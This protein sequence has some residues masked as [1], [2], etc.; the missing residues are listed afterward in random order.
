MEDP[1]YGDQF[2]RD[3]LT[4]GQ[5]IEMK[6]FE[7]RDEIITRLADTESLLGKLSD[8]A[9]G[10]TDTILDILDNAFGPERKKV[11][12]DPE[13]AE[14]NAGQVVLIT[15]EDIAE[16]K[17]MPTRKIDMAAFMTPRDADQYT[18]GGYNLGARREE[19]MR[20]LG[21]DPKKMINEADLDKS[22]ALSETELDKL[23]I[24]MNEFIEQNSVL[25]ANIKKIDKTM[26]KGLN[27]RL[28]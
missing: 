2:T 15:A 5:N 22:G 11:K 16:A 3:L 8:F 24:K 14:I 20:E 25:A 10:S 6:G 17:G 7:A 23:V 27:V 18:G 1:D 13:T 28:E 4:S 9:L 26:L 12:F 21:F 19:A